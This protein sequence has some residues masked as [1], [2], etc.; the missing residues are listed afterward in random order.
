MSHINRNDIK[1]TINRFAPTSKRLYKNAA[2]LEL[3]TTNFTGQLYAAVKT[4]TGRQD[5]TSQGSIRPISLERIMT[6]LTTVLCLV[7]YTMAVC[8]LC[9]IYAS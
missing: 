3:S 6:S 2:Y 8:V 9:C 1:N 5:D 7:C 4:E